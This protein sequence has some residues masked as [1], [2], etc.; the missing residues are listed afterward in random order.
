MTLYL[1]AVIGAA[2][3]LIAAEQIAGVRPT[4]D[5]VQ[6]GAIRTLDCRALFGAPA[7]AP[8]YRILIEPAAGEPVGLIV[9]RL[10]GLAQ[11]A[12]D[13][14]R[15]LPSIGRFGAAIDAVCLLAES[16]NPALRLHVSAALLGAAREL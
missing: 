8:G 2:T 9:D 15:A 6:D 14:F 4:D 7:T 1:K 3:Y 5:L 16:E 12:E 10:D 11:L 13:R